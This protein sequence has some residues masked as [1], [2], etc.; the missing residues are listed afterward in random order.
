MVG[1]G[2]FYFLFASRLVRAFE[3]AEPKGVWK[4]RRRKYV[5]LN[6]GGLVDFMI[7]FG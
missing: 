6:F 4:C 2:I 1:D 7:D 5:R 3:C